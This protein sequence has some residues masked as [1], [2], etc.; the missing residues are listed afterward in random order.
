MGRLA[1]VLSI[2]SDEPV[3]HLTESWYKG[4]KDNTDWKTQADDKK[5]FTKSFQLKAMYVNKEL[6]QIVGD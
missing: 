6:P 3:V 5:I 2:T 1:G 4:K